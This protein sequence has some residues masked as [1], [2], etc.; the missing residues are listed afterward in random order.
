MA[1]YLGGDRCPLRP[2]LTGGPT[3]VKHVLTDHHHPSRPP[4][5]RRS[6]PSLVILLSL[7]IPLLSPIQGQDP[8]R[9]VAISLEGLDRLAEAEVLA[10]MKIQVGDLWE[11]AELDAEYQRLWTSGDFL[12]IEAPLVTEVPEG[13][14]ITIRLEEK[15]PVVEVVFDG[16]QGLSESTITD[17]LRTE[18][19]ELLDRQSL[20]NDREEVRHQFLQL[21]YR[22]VEVDTEVSDIEGGKRV[23]FVIREGPQVRIGS[24]FFDGAES[25]TSDALLEQIS[26]KPRTQFFGIPND[27]NLIEERLENDVEMLKA[28][29]VR[30]G[31]FDATIS[32]DRIL[33]SSELEHAEVVFSIEEGPR[34]SVRAIEFEIEGERV[35]SVERLTEEVGIS[36]GDDWDGDLVDV[37]TNALRRLYSERAYIEA[38]IVPSVVYSLEGFD[39]VLRFSIVEGEKIHV[40]EIQIRGNAETR[41]RVIRRQLVF[42]PGDEFRSDRVQ[43]SW[44]NLN[45]LQYFTAV[46]VSTEGGD[47]PQ[48]R[49]VA[50][51]VEEGSTGRAL[52]GIGITTGR[53]IIGSFSI[54]KRNF[55]ITDFPT[56]I[57]DLPDAFTGGGQTLV[58][59]AQPGTEYSRYR[60]DFREPNFLESLMSLSIR[61]YKSAY[62][63]EDYIEE[64]G[65]SEIAVGRQFL[66]DYNLRTEISYRHEKVSV[67]DVTSTA[68]QIV[69]DSEGTT[70]I[71]AVELSASYDRRKFRQMIGAVDGW[72]ARG[73]FEIAGGPLGE[74]LDLYRGTLSL[75]LYRTVFVQG[76]DLRHIIT[77][78]NNFAWEET[79]GDS[80]FVPI[81]ERFYLGGAG[82][83]RGFRYRGVGPR[84]N[85]R[86]I[87]GTKRHYGSLEYTWPLAENT[88]RGIIF[89]DFG[90]ISEETTG[91]DLDLYRVS[92]GAGVQVNVPFFGQPLP[93]S[94]T[95]A[96]AI[97]SQPDDV[98]QEFLFDI[99]WNF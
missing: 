94:F 65:A 81:F 64:R 66:F 73:G 72:N 85:G 93:I 52:F 84:E 24:V 27:G 55:D 10:R 28:F 96:E 91:F 37:A 16:L 51:Q 18:E 29:Y 15:R 8:P 30:K 80:T 49:N 26:S 14:R 83:L 44:S 7:L 25:F 17:T 2:I 57:G 47:S 31:H 23:V 22:F 76:E 13:V 19:G 48:R 35:F 3:A 53:G 56:S 88:I 59:E 20:A 60:F 78:K 69:A 68:P 70:K 41:D 99:G 43:D 50:V 11:P 32:I 1:G 62:I 87:G 86:P 33:Y 97:Q 21:G 71:S 74:E 98:P 39:L 45:R 5:R 61:G 9:I 92:L 75:G 82:T 42:F 6:V 58:L 12:F 54:Q 40:D 63:R 95:W 89:T 90:N 38:R 34:Y 77:F 46:G 4:P 79:F 36:P 67:V